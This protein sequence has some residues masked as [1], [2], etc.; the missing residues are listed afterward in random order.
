MI[1]QTQNKQQSTAKK[2]GRL[3]PALCN[4]LG[5][6]ILASVILSCLPL[7][8]PRF[9][10]YEIYEVVSGSMEPQIPVG[11]VIYVAPTAPEEIQENEIIA[12]WSG[13]SI[14]THRVMENHLVEGE[15]VTK[16]DANA[17]EDMRE[18]PYDSLIGR[19]SRHIPVLGSLMALYTS[20]VGKAYAVCFSACG[21]MLNI[22]AGRIRRNR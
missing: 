14:I 10:G 17:A 9:L 8:I 12:F 13:D 6:L 11:S 16:G 3:V 21:A 1:D 19:V 7:T 4:I 5:T 20:T 15:F 2:G 22:L 18:A